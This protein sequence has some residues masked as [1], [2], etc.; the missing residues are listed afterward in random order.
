MRNGVDAPLSQI[1]D[2]HRERLR[3]QYADNGIDSFQDHQVLELLLTYAIPRKDTNELAHMLLHQFGS[4]ENVLKADPMQLQTVRGVGP[5]TAQ[6]LRMQ[7]DVTRLVMMRRMEDK[8][9]RVH[10]TCPVDGARLALSLLFNEPYESVYMV[11]LNNKRTVQQTR[12]ISSGTLSEAPIYP[13]IIVENALLH[14]AHSVVLLHNHPSG[15]VLPSPEDIEATDAV[16]AGLKSIDI[17]LLDHLIVGRPY[18]YS[19]SVN[20]V[21]LIRG[22][23]VENITPE[24]YDQRM[25]PNADHC[26]MRERTQTPYA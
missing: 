15:S 6:F 25:R 18:V 16:Q 10:L 5:N 23:L 11:M 22:A 14:R 9:G 8:R 7:S 24:E 12:C 2:G 1:H 21:M 17:Q 3:K 19:F 4:L 26:R 20:I 13:R